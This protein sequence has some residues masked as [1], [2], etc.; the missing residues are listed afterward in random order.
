M[1]VSHIISNTIYFVCIWSFIKYQVINYV[2]YILQKHKF[3]FLMIKLFITT[4]TFNWYQIFNRVYCL[5]VKHFRI[6][7][8]GFQTFTE[9]RPSPQL[10]SFLHLWLACCLT[11]FP[12]SEYG[13]RSVGP[14]EVGC[15]NKL[16]ENVALL[17]ALGQ[18]ELHLGDFVLLCKAGIFDKVE[19]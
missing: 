17:V 19:F 5:Y 15:M 1:Y 4:E 12:D 3:C 18:A 9:L 16:S 10:Y 11:L 13:K 6:E 7:T 14:A 2:L 8:P